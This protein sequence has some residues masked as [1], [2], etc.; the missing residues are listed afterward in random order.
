MIFLSQGYQL[1]VAGAYQLLVGS[2]H[3]FPRLERGGNI[4][5]SRMQAADQLHHRINGRIVQE[6]GKVRRLRAIYPGNRLQHQQPRDF[7]LRM[8][9]RHRI[10]GAAHRAITHQADPHSFPSSLSAGMGRKSLTFQ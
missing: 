3:I 9:L 10:K 8:L 2:D 6:L 4:F 5:I 1:V 7:R